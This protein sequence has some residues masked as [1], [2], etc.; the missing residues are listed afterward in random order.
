MCMNIV[1]VFKYDCEYGFVMVVS[2][3]V[4]ML[5]VV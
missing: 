4:F 2:V 5:C 3:L 1:S